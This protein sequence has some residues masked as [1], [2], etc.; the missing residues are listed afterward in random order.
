MKLRKSLLK[1]LMKEMTM[2]GKDG[3][4]LAVVNSVDGIE[5][6]GLM[7]GDEVEVAGELKADTGNFAIVDVGGEYGLVAINWSRLDLG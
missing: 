2:T 3:I 1:T 6:Y 7:V 5:E 4:D